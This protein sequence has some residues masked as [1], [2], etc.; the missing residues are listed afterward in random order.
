MKWMCTKSRVVWDVIHK[1]LINNGRNNLSYLKPFD[2]D[3]ADFLLIEDNYKKYSLSVIVDSLES[4]LALSRFIES[5]SDFYDMRFNRVQ[6]DLEENS[7]IY[8]SKLYKRLVMLD[9]P[10]S[11]FVNNHNRFIYEYLQYDT[12]KN[13]VLPYVDYMD[14]IEEVKY[15]DKIGSL[16]IIP[17]DVQLGK[18]K[19]INIPVNEFVFRSR[20]T[21][22]QMFNKPLKFS[23][24]LTSNLKSLYFHD[25][26]LAWIVQGIQAFLPICKN[27]DEFR[28]FIM[29]TTDLNTGLLESIQKLQG[30]VS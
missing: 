24:I 5:V 30:K 19:D 16:E 4:G 7:P 26:P 17:K 13:Y 27:L 11:V 15:T 28:I 9:I 10:D 21:L 1:S 2:D 23:T 8:L 18:I 29:K 22:D 3:I 14:K 12:L 6:W 20:E 25:V